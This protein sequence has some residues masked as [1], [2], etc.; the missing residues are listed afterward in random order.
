MLV[1]SIIILVFLL[2]G[3]TLGRFHKPD[4]LILEGA[5][6]VRKGFTKRKKCIVISPIER[7]KAEEA[8]KEELPHPIL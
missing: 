1:L 3:Y 8:H 7:M 4:E 6:K 2:F 5:H